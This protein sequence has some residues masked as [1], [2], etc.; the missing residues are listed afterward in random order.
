[1]FWFLGFNSLTRGV[2]LSDTL[3]KDQFLG[4]GVLET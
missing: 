3:R 4:L 1:M 2:K